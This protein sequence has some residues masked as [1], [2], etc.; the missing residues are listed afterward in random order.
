ML[1]TSAV[2]HVPPDLRSEDPSPTSAVRIVCASG[3]TRSGSY[4]VSAARMYVALTCRSRS[5]SGAVQSSAAIC[6]L[7]ESVSVDGLTE[8]GCLA[9]TIQNAAF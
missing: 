3:A 2:G 1:A 8:T 6:A 5:L 9:E 7:S 4:T